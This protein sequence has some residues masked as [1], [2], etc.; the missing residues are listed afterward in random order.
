MTRPAEMPAA[1]AAAPDLAPASV[2]R[3]ATPVVVAPAAAVAPPESPADRLARLRREA[4]AADARGAHDADK[5]SAWQA[6]LAC[7][8]HDLGVR[9]RLLRAA[10]DSGD[11][12]TASRLASSLD[13]ADDRALV[14]LVELASR[15]GRPQAVDGLIADRIHAGA[16]PAHVLAP[17]DAL[18]ERYPDAARTAL[19]AA[20]AA[21]SASGQHGHALAAFQYA[22]RRGLLSTALHLQWVETCVDA[23]LPELAHAQHALARRY[24]AE[25]RLDEARAVAEDMFVR[26]AGA[27]PSR[28][29]LL[30]ILNR[31]GVAEPHLVLADLLAPTSTGQEEASLAGHVATD[32]G[33]EPTVAADESVDEPP[34]LGD[35]SSAASWASE[36]LPDFAEPDVYV[37]SVAATVAATVAPANVDPLF[38]WSDLLGRDLDFG[39]PV[40]PVV[41]E[42]LADTPPVRDDVVIAEPEVQ[43][44]VE[45][46]VVA[47]APDHTLVAA[48]VEPDVVSEP[49]SVDTAAPEPVLSE[50]EPAPPV[51]QPSSLPEVVTSPPPAVHASSFDYAMAMPRI[52]DL[53]AQP[54]LAEDA[55][56]QPSFSMPRGWLSDTEVSAATDQPR[57]RAPEDDFFFDDDATPARWAPTVRPGSRAVVPP[58]AAAPVAHVSEALVV[59]EVVAAAAAVP[60]VVLEEPTVHEVVH[61]V[62]EVLEASEV[63]PETLVPLEVVAETSV[64]DEL[65]FPELLVIDEEPAP[66]E[67]ASPA[68]RADEDGLLPEPGSV[69]D[70]EID[71]T[72]LLEELKQWDPVLP[73]PRVRT[74]ATGDVTVRREEPES[75][76]EVAPEVVAAPSPRAADPEDV[77]ASEPALS[78]DLLHDPG[79]ASSDAS[80]ELDAVFADLQRGTD[81][82]AVAEQQLAAGRV[83]L[84]AGLASEAARAFERASIE[85]RSRFD[86]SLA[87]A[88]L[89]RSRGQLLDAVSWY[90]L[91]ATAPVPDAA[92]KRAVLYDLAE[93]LEAI[94]ETDRALG[95]LLDLLSQVEDYRDARARLDRLLRVDAGG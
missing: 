5:V 42:A 15:S 80:A 82:R 64:A 25:H 41:L 28:A 92:V 86:A 68:P 89:H 55:P 69:V 53:R 62:P 7:D 73:E 12:D 47:L 35:D 74:V 40:G 49:E 59:P 18:S 37:P 10:C 93:S 67:D 11:F 38:D 46:V 13:A 76:P 94:G 50:A 71:L 39:G 9:L 26:D 90:E 2:A 24:L 48:A 19:S 33:L 22:D 29:L 43:V 60:D 32:P 58:P 66:S 87:L 84:A 63:V 1:P 65:S 88:E 79:Q 8:P 34:A 4:A 36:T 75:P 91:A 56:L 81:D 6:V 70:E 30:D 61:D 57:R 23:G 54:L 17:V 44:H 95:V 20:V 16:L 51:L 52:G 77:V 3:Q 85:P 45:P 83:F 14:A 31:S 27:E 72:Q 21:W 78:D